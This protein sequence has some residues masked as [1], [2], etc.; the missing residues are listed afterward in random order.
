[1]SKETTNRVKN[2][3]IPGVSSDSL[4]AGFLV[5]EPGNRVR[6]HY[7]DIEEFQYIAYGNGV[8]RDLLGTEQLVYP[9]SVIYCAAGRE[10]AHEFENN[11]DLPLAILFI[12]PNVAETTW[13]EFQ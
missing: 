13:V 6:R 3:A 9:G 12:Y 4:L 11:T 10:G 2:L 8:A 7:H 5:L 1:M